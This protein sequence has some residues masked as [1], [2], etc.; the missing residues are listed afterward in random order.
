MGE[1]ELCR[2]CLDASILRTVQRAADRHDALVQCMLDMV[3]DRSAR[4]MATA[5]A[6]CSVRLTRRLQ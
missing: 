2:T 6:C 4:V 1:C 5:D 3:L